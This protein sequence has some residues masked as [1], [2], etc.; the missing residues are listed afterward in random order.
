[1]QAVSKVKSGGAAP[2]TL[3]LSTPN[4]YFSG[5]TFAAS[6]A[7]A[8][9]FQFLNPYAKTENPPNLQWNGSDF[10]NFF[11]L[12]YW[13]AA[14]KWKLTCGCY[15]ADSNPTNIECAYNLADETAIPLTGWQYTSGLVVS[16]TLVI[17]TTP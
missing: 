8:N 7:D 13:S 10:D 3:P 2:T 12:L 5:L 1:M 15:D 11:S 9:S 16:G 17:S 14:N 6:Y 4:L